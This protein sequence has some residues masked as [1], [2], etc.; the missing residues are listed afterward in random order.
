MTSVQ[1][2]DRRLNSSV[3]KCSHISYWIIGVKQNSHFTSLLEMFI[4]VRRTQ[5]T[6]LQCYYFIF[7]CKTIFTGN[8]WCQ[9]LF[10]GPANIHKVLVMCWNAPWQNQIWGF[11][12]SLHSELHVSAAV[13]VQ[14]FC[15]FCI[16]LLFP[17]L[18][19]YNPPSAASSSSGVTTS[20]WHATHFS[21][22]C[23]PKDKT[24]GGAPRGPMCGGW[25]Q[26]NW[27]F[28]GLDVSLWQLV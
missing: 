12:I 21:C 10:M 28:A 5:H 16:S 24:P 1:L 22:H 11:L 20:I 23:C 7:G 25:G 15:L 2:H 4:S 13:Q 17:S 18:T 9:L 14:S 3:N 6:A 19:A 27:M 26:Q 8:C